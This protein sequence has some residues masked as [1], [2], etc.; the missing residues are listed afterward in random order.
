MLHVFSYV[1]CFMCSWVFSFIFY[2]KCFRKTISAFNF[3]LDF[4]FY[5]LRVFSFIVVQVFS[6]NNFWCQF[7]TRFWNLFFSSDYSKAVVNAFGKVFLFIFIQAFLEN[8]RFWNFF[9]ICYYYQ[10]F[11]KMMLWFFD[12]FWSVLGVALGISQ[13]RKLVGRTWI[14][15]RVINSSLGF[16]TTDVG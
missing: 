8:N 12:I 10:S 14:F 5:F 13:P 11:R 3:L 15:L 6:E 4:V 2:S 9:F 1:L 7:S 16:T